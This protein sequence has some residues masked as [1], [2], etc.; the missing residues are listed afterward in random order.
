MCIMTT[1]NAGG[2]SSDMDPKDI[3]MNVVLENKSEKRNDNNMKDIKRKQNCICS[4]LKLIKDNLDVFKR[5]IMDQVTWMLFVG[6]SLSR[7]LNISVLRN[8]TGYKE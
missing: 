5:D 3:F 6:Y 7:N 4:E 2:P 1:P 8:V